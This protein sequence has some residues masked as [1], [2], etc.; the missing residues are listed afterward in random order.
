MCANTAPTFFGFFNSY[1]AVFFLW[2]LHKLVLEVVCVCD[3]GV[4]CKGDKIE[5]KAV[6]V[7]IFKF[8]TGAGPQLPAA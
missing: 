4:C 5:V 2:V 8:P 1:A 7:R 6:K 3:S